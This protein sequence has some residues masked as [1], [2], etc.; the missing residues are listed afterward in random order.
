MILP[1]CRGTSSA[2]PSRKLIHLSSNS[3]NKVPRHSV[4]VY[5]TNHVIRLNRSRDLFQRI[6]WFVSYTLTLC[7]GTL[8][9]EF[10]LTQNP[11]VFP[12]QAQPAK[13]PAIVLVL[14]GKVGFQLTDPL[15]S[16]D[17]IVFRDVRGASIEPQ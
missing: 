9:P 8:F 14:L 6:A 10:T 1:N 3:T 7:R 4:N 11:L 2:I 13:N 16:L 12:N 5:Q 17:T 15:K